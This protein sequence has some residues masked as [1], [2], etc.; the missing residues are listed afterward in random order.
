[1][2]CQEAIDR[3]DEYVDGTLPERDLHEVELHLH[4]CAGCREEERLL[5]SLLTQAAALP[6]RME[7]PRDLWPA[8]QDRIAA[9]AARPR[10]AGSWWAPMALA[11]AAALVMAL[12]ATLLRRQGPSRSPASLVPAL[13]TVSVRPIGDAEADYERATA[14]LLAA[15]DERRGSLSPETLA[16]VD[17]NLAVID[18]AMAE[19]REALRKDPGSP[20]LTRM[21]A[22][23]HRKK[24]DVLQ[25][26]VKLTTSL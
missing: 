12:A 20:Q 1:M 22:A 25:R 9:G 4:A 8:I 13:E 21:L 6:R 15:L 19:V 18:Q 16:A 14:A 10:M 2:S 17:R 5:R 11:V 26:V 23:T 7:P 3:L 24:V